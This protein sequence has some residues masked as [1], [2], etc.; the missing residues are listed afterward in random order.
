MSYVL[1]IDIERSGGRSQDRTIAI[2]ASVV[3]P[4][5]REK[6]RLLLRAYRPST[7]TEPTQF[8]PQCWQSF[9]VK[10]QD[11]LK[12]IEYTGTSSVSER[13]KEMIVALQEF[14]SKWERKI[15]KLGGPMLML[16]S[17]NPV[18]DGGYLNQLIF[19]HLDPGTNIREFCGC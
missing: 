12:Q 16:A 14:R 6:D 13:E 1:A 17:D 18:F 15:S 9:W 2:G 3:G 8:E 4:D 11:V 7:V 19:T 10:N 5:M